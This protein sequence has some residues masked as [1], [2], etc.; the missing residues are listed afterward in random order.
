[1]IVLKD[2]SALVKA[3]V[4]H[5]RKTTVRVWNLRYGRPISQRTSV[6]WNQCSVGLPRQLNGL[7]GY[8][9]SRRLAVL[10]LESLELRIDSTRT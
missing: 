9:Y 8:S 2:R 3:C 5:V 7:T 10:G 6:Q 1:M 4:T